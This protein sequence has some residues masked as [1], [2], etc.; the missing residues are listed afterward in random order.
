MW[1]EAF[2]RR[3][4][5]FVDLRNTQINDFASVRIQCSEQGQCDDEQVH[6]RF[7]LVLDTRRHGNGTLYNAEY[8]L[9]NQKTEA[10]IVGIMFAFLLFGLLASA[11]TAVYLS[12]H[13]KLASLLDF[14]EKADPNKKHSNIKGFFEVM[15]L[16]LYV[17]D[18]SSDLIFGVT[19]AR[20]RS[21][22]VRILS[23]LII[24][25]ALT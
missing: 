25:N 1:I 23:F 14:L 12:P 5:T 16:V 6:P 2:C 3:N 13:R 7:N 4:N 10:Y 9:C 21:L 18:T 24:A 19:N 15:V 20:S 22:M 17:V 8:N 11:L